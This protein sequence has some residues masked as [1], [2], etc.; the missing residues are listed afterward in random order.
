MAVRLCKTYGDLQLF[1]M[2][3]IYLRVGICS[4]SICWYPCGSSHGP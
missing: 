2:H 4:H 3:K 1:L